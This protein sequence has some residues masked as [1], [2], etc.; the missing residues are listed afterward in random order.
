MDPMANGRG[1]MAMAQGSRGPHGPEGHQWS[2]CA[3][4][5]WTLAPSRPLKALL[6]AV[7][8]LRF[9]PRAA[10]YIKNAQQTY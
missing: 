3:S 8:G 4:V 1:P 6:L 10:F 2:R 7:V 5:P 9:G